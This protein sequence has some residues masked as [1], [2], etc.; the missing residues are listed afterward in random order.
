MVHIVPIFRVIKPDM[1]V[2][3]WGVDKDTDYEISKDGRLVVVVFEPTTG[4]LN[5]ARWVAEYQVDEWVDIRPG[6]HD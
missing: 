6:Q 3:V 2:D 5:A 1:A 4:G